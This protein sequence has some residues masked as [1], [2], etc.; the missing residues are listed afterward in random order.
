VVPLTAA[1]SP[2]QAPGASLLAY[3][4]AG[5]LGLVRPG[6]TNQSSCPG[7]GT[8]RIWD[9]VAIVTLGDLANAGSVC[10]MHRTLS[11]WRANFTPSSYNLVTRA[12]DVT[13]PDIQN[14]E[15]HVVLGTPL[16]RAA[17]SSNASHVWWDYVTWQE[18]CIFDQCGN[19]DVNFS[20]K[21]ADDIEVV[22]AEVEKGEVKDTVKDFLVTLIPLIASVIGHD[23]AEIV[24]TALLFVITTYLNIRTWIKIFR[25]IWRGKPG[26]HSKKDGFA[27]VTHANSFFDKKSYTGT[28]PRTCPGSRDKC[29]PGK[30]EETIWT[31]ANGPFECNGPV[32]DNKDCDVATDVRLVGVS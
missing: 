12:A 7:F 31:P 1:G 11:S 14:G 24:L 30:G 21:M 22:T 2:A 27:V 8:F 23:K 9:V 13:G 29:G 10:P 5:Q 6:T 20:A 26:R 17:G 4:R 28:Y 25:R 18:E 16:A 3:V 15:L 19:L 32:P